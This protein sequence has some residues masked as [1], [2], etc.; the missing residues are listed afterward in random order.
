MKKV[1]LW[2]FIT[3]V[4]CLGIWFVHIP[5]LLSPN[6]LHKVGESHH[7]S[8]AHTFL[9]GSQIFVIYALCLMILVGKRYL[10]SKWQP[11]RLYRI[12]AT[13]LAN[14]AFILV[15]LFSFGLSMIFHCDYFWAFHCLEV[16]CEFPKEIGIAYLFF[17]LPLLCVLTLILAFASYNKILSRTN[18]LWLSWLLFFMLVSIV[19]YFFNDGI[20]CQT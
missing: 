13:F 12:C 20:N 2:I 19:I 1:D 5:F 7:L 14:V 4:L 16:A 11:Y 8:Q 18:C 15:W 6:V 3:F 10:D 17:A 9:K